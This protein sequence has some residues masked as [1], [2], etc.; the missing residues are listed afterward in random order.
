M[1]IEKKSG[2]LWWRDGVIYQIYPRSFADSN[3]DGIG[4]LPGITARLDYLA[5]LG[6]DAIW[7]SPINPS[8]DID[9]GYDV[10]DYK[11]VDEKYGTLADFD[12]LVRKAHAVKIRVI[13]D[14]VLNHTSDQ[15]PWFL[16]SRSSKE[17]PYRDWYLWREN[18][19]GK[20]LPPNNWQ[21]IFGGKGWE[22][23]SR[24]DQWYFHMFYK[25]QPDLN[26]RN[27]S[28]RAEMMS[29]FRFWADRGVDGFRLDVFNE[30]F[31]D[32]QLRD[33]PRK[34]GIRPFDQQ[35][36]LYDADQPE[37]DGVVREIRQ[38]LDEYPERYAVGETF[39][40]GGD[41]AALYCQEGKLHGTFDFSFLH[42]P[43]KPDRFLKSILE[44]EAELT[45][46]SW[47]TYVLNN[48]DNPRSA[49][50]FH[51]PEND[52]RL[53]VAAGMLLTLRGTPFLYAGEEIGMRNISVSR[54]EI[55]DP[56]GKHY[57]PFN[58]GRDNCRSPMQ[59]DT[60]VN[61]GF[62]RAT[63]WLK[64]HPRSRERNVSAQRSDPRSLFNF[65]KALLHIRREYPALRKGMFLPLTYHPR[66]VLGYLRQ[67]ADQT[68]L[69]ALN[70][71]N[72]KVKLA[73]GGELCARRWSLLLSNK[74][75]V[76]PETGNG[77]LQLAANE[78]CILLQG[79]SA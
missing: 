35:H 79:G 14:L 18:P 11:A 21:S 19:K 26:W 45:Q 58:K 48:H 20:D 36:H 78:V 6:V 27:E 74:R 72:R 59:W 8:P 52:E 68:I 69:V 24:T 28:V 46:S 39:M 16:Q 7:L 13:L 73:L 67:N 2:S 66:L 44:W 22:F 61:A 56:L 77:W 49:D 76:V 63:P 33:N 17:N 40:G 30:Y 41:R 37:M 75:D 51:A 53:K 32:E 23:D 15:H 34:W 43:W 42:N 31:K 4:D 62:S 5:D 70:F 12:E 64:L 54:G 1:P 3:G 29:V 9:F 38:I 50:R 47:P 55:Q 65:Y 71:G 25:E 60:T 10:S 57:W